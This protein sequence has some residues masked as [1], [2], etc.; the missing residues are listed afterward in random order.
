MRPG[1]E[2]TS[3]LPPCAETMAS[4]MDKPSPEVPQSPILRHQRGQTG[5]R[6]CLGNLSEFRGPLSV[7][8]TTALPSAE[9]MTPVTTVVPGSV[10]LRALDNKLASTW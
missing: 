2:V 5:R 8:V 7:T 6:S 9:S 4:T 10:C 3:T 1:R